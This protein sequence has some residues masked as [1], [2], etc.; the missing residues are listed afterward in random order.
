MDGS[1]I[2]KWAEAMATES[3]MF[4][5]CWKVKESSI[6][7][8]VEHDNYEDA[9]ECLASLPVAKCCSYKFIAIPQ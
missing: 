3:N 6:N 4:I 9:E 1:T 5:V 7:Q 2:F 8:W